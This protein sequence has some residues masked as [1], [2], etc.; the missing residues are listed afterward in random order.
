MI[1]RPRNGNFS[2]ENLEVRSC[3]KCRKSVSGYSD[4]MIS[5][6]CL[7]DGGERVGMREETAFEEVVSGEFVCGAGERVGGVGWEAESTGIC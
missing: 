2:K 3:N 6:E 4:K 1:Y 7:R 5:Y